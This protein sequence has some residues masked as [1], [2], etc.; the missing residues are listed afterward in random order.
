MSI[1]LKL[2]G[3]VLVIT[4]EEDLDSVRETLNAWVTQ[5]RVFIRNVEETD[6][7]EWWDLSQDEQIEAGLLDPDTW[8]HTFSGDH[9]VGQYVRYRGEVIP[10][11]DFSA[12]WGITRGT[13]LPSW[14]NGWSGYASDS[15][16]SGMLIRFNNDDSWE[17]DVTIATYIAS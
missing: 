8:M 4:T 2:A 11:N 6:L 5:P 16:F 14:M 1:D 13:G 10:V 12:D 3:E 17:P 7:V 15:F 9:E